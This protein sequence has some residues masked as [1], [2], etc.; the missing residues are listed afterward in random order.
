MESHAAQNNAKS[1]NNPSNDADGNGHFTIN[2]ATRLWAE[3]ASDG[4]LSWLSRTSVIERGR[5]WQRFQFSVSVIK[6][7]LRVVLTCF[8]SSGS[9][10]G[11]NTSQLP[12]WAQDLPLSNP[13]H[14]P[15]HTKE[16]SLGQLLVTYPIVQE[17]HSKLAD[18]NLRIALAL[19]IQ[20]ALVKDNMRLSNEL[21][22]ATANRIFD[23]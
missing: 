11:L 17:L 18:A 8:I 6:H 19:D 3:F 5:C 15:P 20:A 14:V 1:T 10:T 13:T 21:C 2:V 9:S 22:E 16:V 4:G 7:Q 23:R 12:A